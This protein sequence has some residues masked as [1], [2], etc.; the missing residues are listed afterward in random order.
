MSHWERPAR[1]E[2]CKL[3]FARLRTKAYHGISTILNTSIKS[4]TRYLYEEWEVKSTYTALRILFLL[5]DTFTNCNGVTSPETENLA[6]T[7][8]QMHG[9][10]EWYTHCKSHKATVVSILLVIC[11][12]LNTCYSKQPWDYL[13]NTEARPKRPGRGRRTWLPEFAL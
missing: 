11:V 13:R 1:N 4:D 12:D 3:V 9:E 10:V 8:K 2:R 6:V 7:I 5:I